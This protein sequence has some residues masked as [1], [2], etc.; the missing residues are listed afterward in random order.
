MANIAL[1]HLGFHPDLPKKKRK[2]ESSSVG[3]AELKFGNQ[4]KVI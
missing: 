4:N 1:N 3:Y 2:G